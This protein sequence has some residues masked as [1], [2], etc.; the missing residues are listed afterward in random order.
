MAW[1]SRSLK[2]LVR[3]LQAPDHWTVVQA[4]RRREKDDIMAQN[5]AFDPCF[6]KV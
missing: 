4:K 5:P 3:S 6:M 1:A 2:S